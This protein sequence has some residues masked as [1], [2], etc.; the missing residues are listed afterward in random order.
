MANYLII[1]SDDALQDLMGI[2]DYI[3]GQLREPAIAAAQVN[4]IRE[5]IRSLGQFPARNK[6]VPW[7]PWHSV[8]M[9]QMPVDNF[10]AFYT[11]DDTQVAVQIVRIF[12]GKRDIQSYVRLA[13]D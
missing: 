7:E 8:G 9:R 3:S 11:I 1:Y 2:F 5:Q 13:A 4:R 10:I 6:K 12:Y